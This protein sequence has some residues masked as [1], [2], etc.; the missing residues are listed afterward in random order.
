MQPQTNPLS[1][2][3]PPPSTSIASAQQPG[4]LQQLYDLIGLGKEIW[5]G[6]DPDKYVR[7]L[8]KD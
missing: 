3:D 5:E 4:R 6:V 1:C 8:R 2:I 7:S